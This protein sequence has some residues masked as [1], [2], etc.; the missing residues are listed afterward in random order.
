MGRSVALFRSPEDAERSA[1]SLRSRGFDVAAAPVLNIVATGDAAPT[2][3]FD[4]AVATSA[5]AILHLAPAARTA[6]AGLPLYL[7]GQRAARAAADAGLSPALAPAPDVA[8]L[9]AALKAR[10][11][12]QARVLYL[13][14]RDRKDALEGALAAIGAQT[15]V[16]ET[17]AAGA[18]EGWSKEEAA[19]LARCAAALHYSRRSAAL[20]VSLAAR[21]GLAEHFA[22]I[23]HVCFSADVA[24]PLREVG[25]SH[26]VCAEAPDE[27]HLLAAL[28]QALRR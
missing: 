3:P 19:E 6:I 9:S 18:R 11:A 20:A 22:A 13:A 1:A 12:P 26:I 16:L 17:Y 5:N 27:T 2:G 10:L 15:S 14:G 25:W 23:A 7:V 28:E 4:A 8:A 21:A 24:E